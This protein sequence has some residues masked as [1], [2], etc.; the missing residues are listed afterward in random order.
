V[1]LTQSSLSSDGSG[2]SKYMN[3][4]SKSGLMDKK[5]LFSNFEMARVKGEMITFKNQKNIMLT[6]DVISSQKARSQIMSL[7]SELLSK[8][9]G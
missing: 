3:T 2:I 8:Q 6:F 7:H 1:I 5:K 9:M 4:F